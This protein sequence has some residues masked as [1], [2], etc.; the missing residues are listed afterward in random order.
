[1]ERLAARACERLGQADGARAGNAARRPPRHFQSWSV[2]DFLSATKNV[3]E[4]ML[5]I[6]GA[7]DTCV[8]CEKSK[9]PLNASHG[10]SSAMFDEVEESAAD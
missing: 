6:P 9:A 2:Q 8:S 5:F 1:M 10:D 4:D 3:I 7:I